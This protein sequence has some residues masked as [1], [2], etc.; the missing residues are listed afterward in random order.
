[1]LVDYYPSDVIKESITK[2]MTSY[3]ISYGVSEKNQLR[4][5][6]KRIVFFQYL[7]EA[8]ENYYMRLITSDSLIVLKSIELN[9]ERNAYLCIRSIV[10]SFLRFDIGI[11]ENKIVNLYSLFCS[12]KEKYLGTM[13]AA[14]I[15][16]LEYIYKIS[17]YY[18]HG[19]VESKLDIIKSFN[20]LSCNKIDT[21]KV[22]DILKSLYKVLNDISSI[23]L[24]SYPLLIDE[25]FPREKST[26]QY[27]LNQKEFDQFMRGIFPKNP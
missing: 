22:D 18:V 1:M 14:R 23:L 5:I 19:H 20:E 17:C 26:L 2:F 9:M 24:F 3:V 10:E 12:V 16:S 27:I 25:A 13:I 11:K 15:E 6:L 7:S 4:Y 8:E 21:K